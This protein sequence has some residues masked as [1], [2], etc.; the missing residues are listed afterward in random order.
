[1]SENWVQMLN[2]LLNGATVLILSRAIGD[3]RKLKQ[4]IQTEIHDRNGRPRSRRAER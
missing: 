3:L 2:A 1:V 4:S